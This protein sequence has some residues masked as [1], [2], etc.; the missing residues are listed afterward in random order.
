M[1][2]MN[3]SL[4]GL[5]PASMAWAVGPL[6]AIAVII[7]GY[8]ISKIAAG[9]V[10]GAINR[11]G[12]G[13]QAK[14]TGGNIGKSLSKAV[15]WVLWLVFILLGLSQFPMISEELGFL[16]GMMD[17][18]FGYLPQLV[19]GAVVLGVGVMLANVV[20]NALTST[21]EVAQVDRLANRFNV[22]DTEDGVASNSIAKG[23]GGLAKAI[24]I[25]LFAI[26]AIGIWD[27]PGFSDEVNNMLGTVLEYIPS[28]IGAAIILA[29]AV[30]IGRFVSNLVKSTL[31]ALGVDR[32]LSTVAALDGEGTKVVP[33]NIIAT[34]AFV[35]IVLMGLTAAMKA[36]GIPELT[37]VFNTL[38]EVGGR[39][40]LG[41]IIIGAGLFI[42]NFVSKLVTQ[43]SGDLAGKI[44][45]YA[46]IVIVT[47]MGLET[48]QLGEGI[49][50]TA[51]R[52]SV[53][54]AA[55]AAGVGGAIAF[56]LGGR[57]WAAKKLNEWMP[58]KTTRKK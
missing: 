17:N 42:A 57:E 40:V 35:G 33:S 2:Q 24:V 48:M 19:I 45:K 28:I 51:F 22:N 41:A 20:Q 25:L 55:V 5:L 49:V 27:I 39:V 44:I 38:L 15:F 34:V 58:A 32:S 21:L 8:F 29:A 14:T 52:Y 53:M 31:P 26:A 10:S 4:A 30:F 9:V 23:L 50:D 43:T 56:G 37:N 47:F 1:D 54:A 6:I 18:I 36:L 12:I 46:T 11:T 7:V 13:K 3:Q 16:N